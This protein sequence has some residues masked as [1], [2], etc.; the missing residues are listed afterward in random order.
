M[1]TIPQLLLKRED[2]DSVTDEWM[3][4]LIRSL[5]LFGRQVTTGFSKNITLGE[6]AQAFWKDISFTYPLTAAAPL[7]FKNDLAGGQKPK[8]LIIAQATDTSATPTE[9]PVSLYAPAWKPSGTSIQVSGILGGIDRHTYR[10][11]FLALGG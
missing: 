3:D 6:N 1:A 4:R 8:A 5:N 7:S 10:V 9:L 2:Y 11:T